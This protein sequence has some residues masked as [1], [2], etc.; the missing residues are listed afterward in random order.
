LFWRKSINTSYHIDYCFAKSDFINKIS[1]LEI[2]DH[3]QWLKISDHVPVI[4]DFNNKEQMQSH[5]IDIY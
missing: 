3:S 2:G 4:L 1:S 5:E